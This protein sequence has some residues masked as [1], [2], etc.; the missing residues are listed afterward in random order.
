V[1]SRDDD[2]TGLGERPAGD[3]LVRAVARA[4]IA[5]ELFASD[6]RV[7]LGRYHLLER[8]GEGGM[9]VVWG[10]WDPELERRVA[11]KVV[12]EA[13]QATRDRIL[14]EGQA[15][16][17]LSHPNVV[18]VYDV[19]VV[20]D[21][22]YVVMEWVRG[23]NLRQWGAEAHPPREIVAVYRQAALGLAAAH[24]AGLIHRDFKPDNA[25]R[26]DDGRVRV[27]D[28]GLARAEGD[29]PDAAGTPQYMAPEQ[30]DRQPQTAAV[31]QYAFCAS[32]REALGGE[33]LPG[34]LAEICDRGTA[35]AAGDRF[36]SMDEVIA[37]L[38][39]DPRIVWRRRLL[40]AA[41]LV[42]T[43]G[44]FAVGS[45]AAG[46][47]AVEHCVAGATEIAQTWN[48]GTRAKLLAHL[49]GQGPYAKD[50]AARL[51]R[52]LARYADS[53]SHA[54]DAACKARDR[55]DVTTAL[56]ERGVGCL[57]RARAA[58]G[59]AVDLLA[60]VD[61]TRFPNAVVAAHSLSDPDRCTT[62]TA[63]SKVAPPAREIA[64]PVAEL[65]NQIESARVLA[66][67]VDPRAVDAAAATVTAADRLG[68][69]QL[70]ARA[71]VVHGLALTRAHRWSPAPFD[72]GARAALDADDDE[73]FV[74]AYAREIFAIAV[75]EKTKLDPAIARAPELLPYAERIAT[76]PGVSALAR[77]R[78]YNDL[79]VARMAADDRPGAR[80]WFDKALLEA[81]RAPPAV[82]LAGISGNLALVVD[83]PAARSRALADEI[84]AYTRELGE[85]HPLTLEARLSASVFERDRAA[86]V[87]TLRDTTARMQR[88]HPHLR[89]TVE[90]YL[91]ELGWLLEERGDAAEARRAFADIRNAPNARVAPGYVA[92]LD[93]KLEDSARAMTAVGREL[94]GSPD[95]WVR[96]AASDAYQV[97]AT[98]QT[99]LHREADAIATLTHT[100]PLLEKIEDMP[101]HKRR[102]ARCRAALARL[103]VT[104]EPARARELAALA[105]GWYRETAGYDRELADLAPI[106]R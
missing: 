26:G 7:K 3:A 6:Q 73:L 49:A 56:Y 47:D 5:N 28:F 80:V 48:P 40:V 65:A 82:E 25:I 52:D 11:I 43:A 101:A 19:G 72:R 53:W 59:T 104:R 71:N 9:G 95:I 29:E 69:P 57:E 79:G 22:V 55:G 105:A 38:G 67:A 37:A 64:A 98:A 50:E 34:W 27:L 106:A 44:A 86:T 4:R 99:R 91:Y 12:R 92:L 14:R 54:R 62:E 89:D 85:N 84:A 70:V 42:V 45:Y 41:G 75:A 97:A 32:L 39:R 61:Q 20:D 88:L 90:D 8:V 96:I 51:E 24:G 18:P 10:A 103:L 21:Q 74:E 46:G 76:R 60:S 100:L 2:D 23:K 66:V 1:A 77:A 58:L 68:Y 13:Q 93:G 83:D 81:R 78:L 63:A 15:L 87:E 16:A 30:R 102:L 36:P 31:D 94:E 17:K 33:Q 35:A